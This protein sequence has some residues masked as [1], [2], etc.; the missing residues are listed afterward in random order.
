VLWT[1][2]TKILQT[3]DIPRLHWFG[4]WLYP[5]TQLLFQL[6]QCLPP[7]FRH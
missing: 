2:G 1:T 5:S 4:V 6:V 3:V 7:Y